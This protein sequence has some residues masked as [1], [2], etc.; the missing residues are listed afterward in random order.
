MARQ[1]GAAHRRQLPRL[2]RLDPKP[3]RL[4]A[5]ANPYPLGF[6]HAML[7]QQILRVINP[8]P[9]SGRASSREQCSRPVVFNQKQEA[10]H[11][12][13]AAEV[14][15]D[16]AFTHG[17]DLRS[18]RDA[19]GAPLLPFQALTVH[20]VLRRLPGPRKQSVRS[21]V[22]TTRFGPRFDAL[23][24]V[25]WPRALLLIGQLPRIVPA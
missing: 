17:I 18:I 21:I 12:L 8:K 16:A 4:A 10:A 22:P 5:L 14:D 9:A 6:P 25:A 11:G 2:S 20:R 19:A 13:G 7:V 15:S 24:M 1:K 3:G 23:R